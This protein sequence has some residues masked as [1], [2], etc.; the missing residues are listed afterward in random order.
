ML[1][2]ARKV[3]LRRNAVGFHLLQT[4]SHRQSSQVWTILNKALS[5]NALEVREWLVM[6][7]DKKRHP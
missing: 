1:M 2:V 7:M 6:M 5:A 3:R 4:H